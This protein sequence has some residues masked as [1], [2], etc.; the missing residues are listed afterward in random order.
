M[1]LLRRL[2][3]VG[4]VGDIYVVNPGGDGERYRRE[5]D[6]E[7]ARL[8]ER[9]ERYLV[10]EVGVGT[11]VAHRTIVALFRHIGI[12]GRDCPC[13]CH[14]QLSTQHDD[15]FDCRCSWD[16]ARREDEH[17]AWQQ[18]LDRWQNSAEAASLRAADA[19]EEAE[20]AEWIERE[21]GVTAERTTSMVP[22]QWEGV[23]DGHSFYFRERHGEWRIE[24]DLEET[25]RFANRL[26]RVD[27]DGELVTEP[28]PIRE[29]S[30]IAEGVEGQL[31]A[32]AVDHLAFIVRTV[33]DHV[34]GAG[35]DH[36]GALAFCPWCGAR[37]A[38]W[39]DS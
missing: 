31:G 22:E 32:Y 23:I 24:L 10:D 36:A 6:A 19:A 30:V 27:D 5:R 13:S 37:M 25:G 3:T 1:R 34:R 29:G 28:V 15:G 21:P 18:D 33:R 12:D 9:Y 11:D 26:V 4:G 8:R 14:P 7:Q 2:L 20:I 16:E 17:R 39:H 38:D 35:C